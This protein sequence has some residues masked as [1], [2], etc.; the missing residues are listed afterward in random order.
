MDSP[1]PEGRLPGAGDEPAFV[2]SRVRMFARIDHIGV[3][4]EDLD[5][6]IALHESTYGMALV[7]REIGERAGRRGRAARRRREPR[8][9]AARRSADDTPV[10]KFLARSG[11]GLHHVAYQVPDIE[12]ALAALK[13]DGR[14]ADRRDAAHR[15]PQLARR[16]RAPQEL[17]RRADRDRPTGGGPLME[18][19]TIGFFGGALS[20]RVSTDQLDTLLKA[21]P[22]G[23]LARHRG[24]GRRGPREP[25]ARRLRAHGPR[26]AHRRIRRL[27]L[28]SRTL[29]SPA[30]ASRARRATRRRPSGPSARSP[31]SASTPRCGWS[32][33]AAGA[34]VD[35]PRRGAWVRAAAIVAGDVRR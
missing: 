3:A 16:V 25:R 11:P 26:Q 7:H 2:D 15:H 1:A 6:A 20:L 23:R 31:R 30:S 24:R 28:L 21:L 10:G 35:R 27:S 29:T 4:V 34:A 13:A 8:R 18:K 14:A 12:A 33:G 22:A 5:A 19:V 17:G 9:A 32:L